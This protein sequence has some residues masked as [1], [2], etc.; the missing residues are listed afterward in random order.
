MVFAIVDSGSSSSA[1]VVLV[2]IFV[3]VNIHERGN[4]YSSNSDV[5]ILLVVLLVVILAVIIIAA[6]VIVFVFLVAVFIND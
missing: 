5:V 1:A 6:L 4:D 2:G 3:L